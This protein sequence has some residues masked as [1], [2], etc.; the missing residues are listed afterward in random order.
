MNI[1]ELFSGAKHLQQPVS[2]KLGEKI[3]VLMLMMS[4]TVSLT[5]RL[6]ACSR[7]AI[8]YLLTKVSLCLVKL[9]PKR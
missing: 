5:V 8:Q 4:H 7:I 2:V 6:S 9:W 3:K 1:I